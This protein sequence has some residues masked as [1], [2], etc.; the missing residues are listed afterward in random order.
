[1]QAVDT[2]QTEHPATDSL[3]EI[4]TAD[5]VDIILEGGWQGDET[6]KRDGG[7]APVPNFIINDLCEFDADSARC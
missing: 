6:M 3:V 4:S 7:Q 1:M 5:Y 2:T